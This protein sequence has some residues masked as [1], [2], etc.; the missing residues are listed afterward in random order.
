MAAALGFLTKGPVGLIIPALVVI[1]VVLIERRSITVELPDLVLALLVF[2]VIAV[3]WY[4][5]MWL[6]HGNA[7]LAGFFVG[8][9][10]DR[11]ATARFNDPRPW[12]FYLPVL[13][14]GLLPWT[15]ILAVWLGSLGRFLKR[16]QDFTTLDLRLLMWA[17]LPLVFY[18]L[19]VGK[20]PRYVLPVLPPVAL[21]LAASVLERTRQWRSLDGARSRPRSSP[22]VVVGCVAAGVCLI[23]IALLIYRARSL[24]IDVNDTVTLAAIVAIAAAGALVVAVSF[25]AAWRAAPALLALAGAMTFAVLPYGILAM[26]RDS[27]VWRMAQMVKAANRNARG[28]GDLSRLR[29]QFDLLHG[30]EA[31]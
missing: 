14:G 6:H 10:Y 4:A 3:P 30:H 19:A 26:P 29:A 18:T 7:Y 22:A 21:L 15:P 8:D 2:L 13:A 9:N 11:F 24:F 12:W 28:C 25:T 16:R 5:A 17:A 31:R 27:A 20:Q 23:V 1:P